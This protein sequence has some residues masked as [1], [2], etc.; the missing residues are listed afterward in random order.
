M[1]VRVLKT[2]PAVRID[3]P[4]ET[5]QL[6]G[7]YV[8]DSIGEDWKMWTCYR[9]VVLHCQ[10]GAGK[11]TFT[12]EV[13]VKD[14]IEK[15]KR[16]VLISNR[17]SQDLACKKRILNKYNILNVW[18]DEGLRNECFFGAHLVIMTYQKFFTQM[19]NIDADDVEYIV[20][21]E[22][23]YFLS[24]A[25]FS[26]ITGSLLMSIPQKFQNT[27]RIYITAT[28]EEVLPYIF[29]AEVNPVTTARY[30]M[31]KTLC[32]SA[33]QISNIEDTAQREAMIREFVYASNLPTPVL[34]TLDGG[35][36]HINFKF[37]DDFG[38][39]KKKI[40]SSSEKWII[41][42]TSKDFG[43]HL[44]DE[45]PDSLYIDAD[46]K[47]QKTETF[48]KL[49]EKEMFDEKILIC[50]SVFINGNNIKDKKV[51]NI[52]ILNENLSDIKQAIGRVRLFDRKNEKL[53]VFLCIPKFS[54]LT[55]KINEISQILEDCNIA[56]YNP[57]YI[58]EMILHDDAR[59]KRLQNIL[60]V[61]E[62]GEFDVNF[63][64]F[65]KLLN[66]KIFLEKTLGIIAKGKREYCKKIAG[67]FS[68]PFKNSMCELLADGRTVIK[69]SLENMVKNSPLSKED[70]LSESEKISD[71]RRKYEF[72]SK[73]DN[74][75]TNRTPL[76][77]NAFN[78]RLAEFKFP[79]KVEKKDG[80]YSVHPL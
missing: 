39:I 6:V 24:D 14:A 35:Y 66:E 58:P 73:S 50:T 67:I 76:D 71:L 79:Y 17:I 32:G 77:C 34:Y 29:K 19:K 18:T 74:F 40:H 25:L 55:N 11:T 26:S 53:N 5:V 69:E 44:H 42:I 54:Q 64:S 78:A 7:R 68:V 59:K 2:N 60:F 9:A 56:R 28:P 57:K 49:I 10:T 38:I 22:A 47:Q 21:D 20:M 23:H 4:Y 63:L 1:N 33:F 46:T 72:I 45:F 13:L 30:R 37:F 65:E 80:L 8:T 41:F 61:N 15:N 62:K 16:I 27:K 31:K 75:G 36:R 51:R 43:K 52:V 48:T 70:F 3:M 12:E